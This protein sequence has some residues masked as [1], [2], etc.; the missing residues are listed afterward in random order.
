MFESVATAARGGG[1]EEGVI[2]KPLQTKTPQLWLLCAYFILWLLYLFNYFNY[3]RSILK[4]H[5]YL[6]STGFKRLLKMYEC[7]P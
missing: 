2:K 7:Q 6:G 1:V 4:I 3:L 5:S